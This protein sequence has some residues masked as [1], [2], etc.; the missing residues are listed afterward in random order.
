[1]PRHLSTGHRVRDEDRISCSPEFFRLVLS[2]HHLD[3]NIRNGFVHGRDVMIRTRSVHLIE[4][5]SESGLHKIENGLFLVKCST[6]CL[7]IHDQ[8]PLAE[9]DS[10]MIS[11]P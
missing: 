8:S 1:M 5:A 7:H 6:G 2:V 10:L 11:C 9:F 3:Q 4:A